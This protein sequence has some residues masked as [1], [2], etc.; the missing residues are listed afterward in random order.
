MIESNFVAL[1]WKG[2]NPAAASYGMFL[3]L[4]HFQWENPQPEVPIRHFDF[5]APIDSS[6]SFLVAVTLE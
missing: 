5:V 4:Y 3:R 2:N 6:A 1:P